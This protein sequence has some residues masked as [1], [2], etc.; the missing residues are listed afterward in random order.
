MSI[1]TFTLSDWMRAQRELS[2][3]SMHHM[4][5]VARAIRLPIPAVAKAPHAPVITLEFPMDDMAR[6]VRLADNKAL[7]KFKKDIEKWATD[8]DHLLR[9]S[10]TARTKHT[11]H[12]PG[13]GLFESIDHYIKLDD[14]YHAEPVK[15]G[16]RFR[17]QG[18]YLH[19]G[20]ARG[21]G[22]NI[23]SRWLDR[24]GVERHTN[25]KSLGKAGK[26]SRPPVDWFN[27][28]LEKE[29][30]KLADICAGYCAEM[31]VNSDF[32]YI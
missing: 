16:F 21:Y 24:Y 18:V 9:I 30:P 4:R 22:R 14:E 3:R 17:R 29:L 13:T 11:P 1:E 7:N 25:P 20:A 32:I 23:G 27:T 12:R 10:V 28:V 19:Y 8:C 5:S 31:I 2:S 26:G 15:V 6:M